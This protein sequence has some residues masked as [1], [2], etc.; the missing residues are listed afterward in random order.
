MAPALDTAPAHR[1]QIGGERMDQITRVP[2]PPAG[3]IRRLPRMTVFHGFGPMPTT[4]VLPWA[5]VERPEHFTRGRLY[6]CDPV[7]RPSG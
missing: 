2:P 5:L 3:S 6:H 4:W 7:V 1:L